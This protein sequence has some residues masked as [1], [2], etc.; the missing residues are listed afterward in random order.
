MSRQPIST[1][2]RGRAP[3]Q[4]RGITLI[5]LMVG[6]VIALALSLVMLKTLLF[7][8]GQRRTVTSGNDSQQAGAIGS[9]ILERYLRMGGAGIT[10]IDGARGC[11]LNASFKGAPVVPLPSGLRAPFA[12]LAGSSLPVAPVLIANGGS[13][14]NGTA[15]D[16]TPD[17]IVVMGGDH[18]SIATWLQMTDTSTTG[19]ATVLNSFGVQPGDLVLAVETDSTLPAQ[20][21]CVVAQNTA[22]VDPTPTSPAFRQSAVNG[23]HTLVLGGD[24]TSAAGLTVAGSGYGK[25]A[26]LADLGAQPNFKIFALSTASELV[27]YDLLDGTT[28]SLA[29]GFVNLQAAYGLSATPDSQDTT[30]VAWQPPT[31]DFLFSKLRDGSAASAVNLHRIRAVRVAMITRSAVRERA[32]IDGVPATW[33][34]MDDLGAAAVTGTR[35]GT[36]LNYRYRQSDVIVTLRNH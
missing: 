27:S 23:G 31:G 3:R 26:L 14:D 15:D 34:L 13:A 5:E 29:D 17:A 28:R 2:R 19:A 10:R 25:N 36:D 6:L 32:R 1:E 33:A 18:P 30:V 8:E 21:T 9:Y 22:A 35:S 11:T 12:G 16:A 20:G 7:A 4:Q 24:H